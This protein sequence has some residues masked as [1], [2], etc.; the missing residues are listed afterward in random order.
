MVQLAF[1]LSS[2][3]IVK[4]WFLMEQI[5]FQSLSYIEIGIQCG[6]LVQDLLIS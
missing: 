3:I 6:L 1:L 5:C 2:E 4:Q